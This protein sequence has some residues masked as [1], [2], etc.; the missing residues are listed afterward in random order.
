MAEFYCKLVIPGMLIGLVLY[1][2][3]RPVRQARLRRKGLATFAAREWLMLF[4]WCY[5]GAIAMLALTPPGFQIRSFLRGTMAQPFFH[6]GTLHLE[7]FDGLDFFQVLTVGNVVLFMPF[8]FLAAV[9]WR[10][11]KW[12]HALIIAVGVTVFIECWQHFVG[13][14]TELND[15]ILNTAGGMLGWLVW[16]VS[17]RP[18]L[19]CKEK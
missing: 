17:G 11:E 10:R 3:M 15:L 5:C 16:R 7:L 6:P 8:P 13:R 4:F 14:M 12:Y 2:A 19:H 9:L 18:T 1:G